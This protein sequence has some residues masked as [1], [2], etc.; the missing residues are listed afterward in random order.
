[1]GEW[2]RI[3]IGGKLTDSSITGFGK[4]SAFLF[5]GVSC[6]ISCADEMGSESRTLGIDAVNTCPC[7]TSCEI[8]GVVG[9][10]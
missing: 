6:S 7:S 8:I 10:C 5:I 9:L 1:M 2:L 3:G 4:R